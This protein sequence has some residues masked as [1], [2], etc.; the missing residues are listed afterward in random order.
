MCAG[1]PNT[2]CISPLAVHNRGFRSIILILKHNSL[3][4]TDLSGHTG[5]WLA[6]FDMYVNR[7]ALGINLRGRS[8]TLRKQVYSQ[9]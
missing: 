5:Q 6:Q 4:N 8:S 2:T 3:S 7:C 9:K 1:S